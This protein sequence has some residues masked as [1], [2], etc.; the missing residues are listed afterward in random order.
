M[1]L[2][3]ATAFKTTYFQFL[4]Q[5]INQQQH[6]HCKNIIVIWSVHSI[7]NTVSISSRFVFTSKQKIISIRKL[8]LSLC[9]LQPNLHTIYNKKIQDLFK[10]EPNKMWSQCTN[11]YRQVLR[12][13]IHCIYYAPNISQQNVETDLFNLSDKFGNFT[14]F[15]MR[16]QV[17]NFITKITLTN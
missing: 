13:Y 1:L 6:S 11:E 17:F 2:Q 7:W 10:Y 14:Q 4:Q 5:Y 12:V 9:N 3:V 8:M 15:K 16:N